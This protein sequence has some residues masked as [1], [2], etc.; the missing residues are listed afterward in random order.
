MPSLGPTE[1]LLILLLV[2]VLFGAGWVSGTIDS[3]GKGIRNFRAEVR[4]DQPPQTDE[5]PRSN[6][7]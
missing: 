5:G 6:T 1:I 3:V 7:P 4:K 2:I